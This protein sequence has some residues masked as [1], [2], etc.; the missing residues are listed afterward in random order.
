MAITLARTLKNR[1]QGRYEARASHQSRDRK[2]FVGPAP[3][4]QCRFVL[5]SRTAVAFRRDP[6]PPDQADPPAQSGLAHDR[7]AGA[8]V[9]RRLF[10]CR[11]AQE[12]YRGKTAQK[13][14]SYQR[15]L[16]KSQP[17][18]EIDPLSPLHGATKLW[19]RRGSLFLERWKTHLRNYHH[20]R[21]RAGRSVTSGDE[22]TSAALP[23]IAGCSSPALVARARTH[24][25]NG[26]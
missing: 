16:F 9:I 22:I 1:V 3:G 8:V 21:I 20:A 6:K 17:F 25:A 19:L 14:G 15:S 7:P 2:A 12:L 4:D 10:R 13:I 24:R 26:L 18:D 23:A 11:T 5:E